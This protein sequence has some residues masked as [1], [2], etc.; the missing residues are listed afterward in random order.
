MFCRNET[1]C[2]IL[3]LLMAFFYPSGAFLDAFV[4]TVLPTLSHWTRCQCRTV[5]RWF[6]HVMHAHAFP[7]LTL[8]DVDSVDIM[9]DRISAHRALQKSVQKLHVH[10][11]YY[12]RYAEG[13]LWRVMNATWLNDAH[14]HQLRSLTIHENYWHP[15][16]A[17]MPLPTLN[18]LKN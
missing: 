6:L 1:S 13:M 14:A 11:H 10:S 5:N 18:L 4:E 17:S 16:M 7:T 3:I 9:F 2:T 8:S 15:E 12:S